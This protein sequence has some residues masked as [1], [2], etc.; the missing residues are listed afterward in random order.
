MQNQVEI[1]AMRNYKAKGTGSGRGSMLDVVVMEGLSEE[2]TLEGGLKEGMLSHPGFLP[3]APF[4]VNSLLELCYHQVTSL[5]EGPSMDFFF[6]LNKPFWQGIQK[7][8]GSGHKGIHLPSLLH[9][10]IVIHTELSTVPQISLSLSSR[11]QT[12]TCC[13]LL[14][15]SFV[16]LLVSIRPTPAGPSKSLLFQPGFLPFLRADHTSEHCMASPSIIFTAD[17]RVHSLFLA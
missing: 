13:F 11:T 6:P 17:H 7:P 3:P 16:L 5:L 10:G 8:S 1:R 9:S 2:V 14:R 12:C 4:P 15:T